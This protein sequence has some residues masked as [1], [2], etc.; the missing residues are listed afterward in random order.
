MNRFWQKIR[1]G[2]WLTA[3]RLQGYSIILLVLCAIAIVVWVAASDGLIDRR[4]EPIGTD[5]SNVYAAGALAWQGLAPDAYDPGLQHAAEQAIF[6]G[7]PVPFYGWHYP[8]FFFAIAMATAAFPYGWGLLLWLVTSLSGYLVTVCAIVRRPGT[9]LPALAFPAVFINIGHGQNAFFTATLIGGALV[10]LD[11][12]PWVSGIL[13]GLLIYKPQFGVLIPIALL[14]GGR[15]TTFAAAALTA[16]ALTV[17]SFAISGVEIWHAFAVS[18][19]FTRTV[20]LEQGATGWHKIQSLFSAVR[21]W[22]GGIHLAY[23]AQAMLAAA[24]AISIAWLW[25]SRASYDLK[26]AALCTA[27]LLVTPYVLDYDLVVLGI[28]IAF[29]ARHGLAHGFI[30]YELSLLALAWIMPLLTRTVAD[31]SGLPL[32]L[33]AMMMLYV[34]ILRRAAMETGVIFRSDVLAKA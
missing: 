17:A 18:T 34:V 31:T 13:I 15:W 19:T 27:S 33:I 11:R 7:R 14:A 32:G 12:R 28:A 4:G 25:R 30:S 23:A 6:G 24:L 16:S 5:F 3:E 21:M 10:L 8:P 26:A 2:Q 22:G 9:W 20:I 1:T 29:L